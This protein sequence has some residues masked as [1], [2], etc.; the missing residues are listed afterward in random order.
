MMICIF[1]GPGG[2]SVRVVDLQMGVFIS[3]LIKSAQNLTPQKWGAWVARKKTSVFHAQ[4]YLQWWC[5]FLCD[6]KDV[7][8][9]PPCLHQHM[10]MYLLLLLPPSMHCLFAGGTTLGSH[11][12]L[13]VLC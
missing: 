2:G 9:L 3:N 5:A 1:G 10:Q 7:L 13:A 4:A 12:S 11:C 8:L 6:S